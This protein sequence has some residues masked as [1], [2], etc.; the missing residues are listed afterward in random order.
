MLLRKEGIKIGKASIGNVNKVDIM[1]AAAN[2]QSNKLNSIILGFNVSLEEDVQD[3][4]IKILTNDVIYKLIE[5]FQKWRTEMQKEIQRESLADLIMP[6]KIKAL[7]FMFRQSHPAIFGVHVEAG[8]L[9]TGIEVM[10]SNGEKIGAIKAIQSENKSIE[11]AAKNMEV[12][13]SMPGVT[14]GRQVKEND[15]LYSDMGEENFHNLKMNKQY[16]SQDEIVVLQEIAQIKRKNKAT[17]G[18]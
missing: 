5:D 12:A 16:L 9:K 3:A 18:I 14:F 7:R 2:L 17:W 13:V 11:K 8:T 1:N 6:C 4:R 15:V 10:N